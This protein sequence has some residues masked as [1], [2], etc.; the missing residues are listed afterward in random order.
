VPRPL[1]Y[2]LIVVNVTRIA[3][4]TSDPTLDQPART[5]VAGLILG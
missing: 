5:A 3:I 2:S 1:L 4:F